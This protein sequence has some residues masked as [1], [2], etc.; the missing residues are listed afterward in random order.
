MGC[1]PSC[2]DG[3]PDGVLFSAQN[4]LHPGDRTGIRPHSDTIFQHLQKYRACRDA[5]EDA[6]SSTPRAA[7]YTDGQEGT[8]SS[9]AQRVFGDAP[10]AEAP[11]ADAPA[12]GGRDLRQQRADGS[13]ARSIDEVY[14]CADL[15]RGAFQRLL[16][17]LRA[18][19]VVAPLKSRARALEKAI[20]DYGDRSPGPAVSWLFDIVRGSVICDSVSGM[21]AALQRLEAAVAEAGGEVVRVKNRLLA[22]TPSGFRDILVHLRLSAAPGCLHTCE[23]QLHHR[24]MLSLDRALGSHAVYEYFRTYFSGNMGTVRDRI[25][26]LDLFLS[27]LPSPEPSLPAAV[28]AA[29][30]AASSPSHLAALDGLY[31][32]LHLLGEY[33]SCVSLAE[34]SLS[35]ARSASRS[36]SSDPLVAS[37]MLELAECLREAGRPPSETLPL[38]RSA[39]RVLSEALGPKSARALAAGV[40]LALSLQRA[41]RVSEAIRLY[42]SL[43]PE[44]A[45]SLGE[46]HPYT[47]NAYQNLGALHSATGDH[48][49][50]LPL[51]EKALEGRA[52]A[53]GAP[54]AELAASHGALAR[55]RLLVG[56]VRGARE[57]LEQQLRICREALGRGHPATALAERDVGELLVGRFG[58]RERG[59]GLMRAALEGLEA[60]L[61]PGDAR[62]AETRARLFRVEMRG[63]GEE[64]GEEEEEMR[65]RTPSSIF[66]DVEQGCAPARRAKSPAY[67]GRVIL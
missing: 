25:A 29:R 62:V 12:A 51:Y 67:R 20:D 9:A 2:D 54:D 32:L 28:E 16:G 41:D 55:G 26:G 56:D 19:V 11:A 47:A 40:N 57:G 61:P 13:V 44:L 49:A 18:E 8:L 30:A 6:W 66:T 31:A 10:A 35:I 5:M 48:W 52:R 22:P 50:A 33:P 23:V 21:Q 58:E 46:A 42:E 27:A 37:R 14:E 4:P 1:C 53:A 59:L 39:R 45:A 65:A 60:V 38:V 7:R 36:P 3:P 15:A 64:E 63:A 43:L 24:A 34:L 17:R